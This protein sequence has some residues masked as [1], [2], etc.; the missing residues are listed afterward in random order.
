VYYLAAK[1][2]HSSLLYG[3]LGASAALLFGLYL[4]GRLVIGSAVFNAALWEKLHRAASGA[5]DTLTARDAEGLASPDAA[6]PAVAD[7]GEGSSGPL[8][9]D[10]Q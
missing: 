7:L 4:V 9:P 6:A 5:P 8:S 1:L 10:R 3:T 2:T